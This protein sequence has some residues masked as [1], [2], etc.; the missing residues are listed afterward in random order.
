MDALEEILPIE[1]DERYSMV[2]RNHAKLYPDLKR[3]KES[4]EKS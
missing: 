1:G 3:T 4:L 2:E